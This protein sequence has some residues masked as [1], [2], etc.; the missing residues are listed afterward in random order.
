MDWA[1]VGEAIG[2]FFGG[3]GLLIILPPIFL[4]RFIKFLIR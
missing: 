4:Y 2:L 3:L 1:E